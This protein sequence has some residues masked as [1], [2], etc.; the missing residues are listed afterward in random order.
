MTTIL[1]LG[2][3]RLI[4][5]V[6]PGMLAGCIAA[7]PGAGV[8][9]TSTATASPAPTST[10]APALMATASLIPTETPY[11]P[12]LYRLTEPGCCV[13]PFWKADSSAVLYI[14]RPDPEGET[15]VYGVRVADLNSFVDSRPV[16]LPSRDGRY[17]AFFNTQGETEILDTQLNR[18]WLIPNDG[19][20][21]YFS[22]EATSVLWAETLRL[23]NGSR[24]T[25]IYVADLTGENTRQV[26]TVFGGGFGGWLDD[27]TILLAGRSDM[28]D[29]NVALYS[30]RI[31]DG[32]RTDLALNQRIRSVETAPGGG[33]VL[34]SVALDSDEGVNGLWV[35]SRDGAQRY[36]LDRVGATAWRDTQRLILIPQDF[37]SSSHEVWQF[38]AEAGLLERLVDPALAPFRIAA[39]DFSVSPDGRYMA[40]VNAADY[41]IWLLRLPEK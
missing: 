4:V 25:T 38:D 24:R 12:A 26:T 11:L 15:A 31:G 20:R 8:A 13:E 19:Q 27:E 5:L 41:A 39:G 32:A 23:N 40:F 37:E 6:L 14:D 29:P 18:N 17:L 3:I 36:Q 9:V 2:L 7:T 1:R 16:G 28:A 34:Y 30:Y 21:I 10:D 35:V 22:P 33:W